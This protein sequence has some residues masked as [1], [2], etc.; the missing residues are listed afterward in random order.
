MLQ[1]KTTSTDARIFED[2]GK[3]SARR[4]KEAAEFIAFLR[5]KEELEATKEIIGDNALLKSIMKGDEDFNA[6]RVKKCS[7]VKEDV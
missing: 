1:D 4:K 7:E 6:G 5:V 2:F 3:L